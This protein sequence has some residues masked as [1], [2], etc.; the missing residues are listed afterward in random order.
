[1][2]VVEHVI[3]HRPGT[4]GD[5]SG[6]HTIRADGSREFC[7]TCDGQDPPPARAIGSWWRR[8]LARLRPTPTLYL[9][10][11]PP[12]R[13]D[14]R[15]ERVLYGKT[16]VLACVYCHRPPPTSL[17]SGGVPMQG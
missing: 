5:R 13:C 15:Y 11:P 7:P 16:L 14:C 9:M 8:L 6:Q 4:W 2:A 1:M 10:P 12:A 17:P 3:C